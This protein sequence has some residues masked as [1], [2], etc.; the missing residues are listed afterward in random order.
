LRWLPLR[1]WVVVEDHEIGLAVSESRDALVG[2]EG[3]LERLCE[4][5]GRLTEVLWDV[6]VALVLHT[7]RQVE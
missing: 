5:V 4:L 6:R 2:I 1:R 7:E 3:R